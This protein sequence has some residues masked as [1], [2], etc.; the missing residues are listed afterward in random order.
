MYFLKSV[1]VFMYQEDSWSDLKGDAGKTLHIGKMEYKTK[2]DKKTDSFLLHV[3]PRD[4]KSALSLVVKLFLEQT[5]VANEVSNIHDSLMKLIKTSAIKEALHA[6]SVDKVC[7]F[8][9]QI[10]W[11]HDV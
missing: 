4:V 6:T 2:Y 10:T 3:Y 8:L 5:K 11:I 7:V 1:Y 9:S